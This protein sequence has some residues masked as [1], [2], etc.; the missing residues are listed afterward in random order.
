MNYCLCDPPEWQILPSETYLQAE[1]IFL[2]AENNDL[3]QLQFFFFFL[4]TGVW[5][6]NLHLKQVPAL[7]VMGFFKIG[8]L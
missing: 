1:L 7:F 8:S 2:P 6:Q 5:T 4:W 3:L